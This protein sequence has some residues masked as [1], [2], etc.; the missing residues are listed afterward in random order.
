[1]TQEQRNEYIKWSRRFLV[2]GAFAVLLWA[3]IFLVFCFSGCSGRRMYH[4]RP[5]HA[6]RPYFVQSVR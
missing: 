1:M 5:V 2:V 4:P 3:A 6:P